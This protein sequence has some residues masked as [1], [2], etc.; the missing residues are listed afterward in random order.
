MSEQQ[1]QNLPVPPSRGQGW[2]GFSAD[3]RKSKFQSLRA[4]DADRSNAGSML[5]EAYAEGRLDADEYEQRL[6]QTRN[7][8]TLGELVPIL[9]DVTPDP[10]ARAA[11]ASVEKQQKANEIIWGVFPRWWL[12]L[13]VMLNAIWLMTVLTSGHFIYYWPMWPMLGTAI[14]MLMGLMS[15]A[16]RPK[17]SENRAIESRQQPPEDDLR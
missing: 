11:A 9:A 5:A 8:K 2:E 13:A 12:G 6:D 15:G 7:S 3:P 17:R 1:W 14:P 10:K 16:G 4:S